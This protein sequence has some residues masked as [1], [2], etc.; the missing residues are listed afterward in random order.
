MGFFSSL[1]HGDN[2]SN[3]H[4]EYISNPC[5][6]CG[7]SLNGGDL[8]LPWEDGSNPNAYVTCPHCGYENIKYGYG[9][10]D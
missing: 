3:S 1:F 9:E 6:S 7:Q 10:D 4:E 2:N 5:I 8:T